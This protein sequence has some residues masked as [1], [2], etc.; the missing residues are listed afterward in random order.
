M[1]ILLS[2][3]LLLAVACAGTSAARDKSL[4]STSSLSC[5][6][7]IPAVAR[8]RSG[9]YAGPDGNKNV[10]RWLDPNTPVCASPAVEGFGFRR[11][12]LADGSTGFVQDDYLLL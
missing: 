7:F 1:R 8:E 9:V 6:D 5:G 2:L 10:V 12:K 4:A 11:V 3:P